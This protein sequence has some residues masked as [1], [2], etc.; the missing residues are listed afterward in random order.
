MSN[1][2]NIK[3]FC[4]TLD[5]SNLSNLSKEYQI[6]FQKSSVQALNETNTNKKIAKIV[7][8]HFNL[9]EDGSR[10]FLKTTDRKKGEEEL[11]RFSIGSTGARK[12]DILL[13]THLGTKG[14]IL[15][16]HTDIYPSKN[17]LNRMR[18]HPDLW[19]Q[20]LIKL[21]SIDFF[22]NMSIFE[23]DLW[24]DINEKTNDFFEDNDRLQLIQPGI[25]DFDKKYGSIFV[26]YLP[27]EDLDMIM[28][29]NEDSK[30][31]FWS[32]KELN[33]IIIEYTGKSSTLIV[34][35]TFW[36][37]STR[38]KIAKKYEG[39][40]ID[41][42]KG[43]LEKNVKVENSKEEIIIVNSIIKTLKKVKT[44]IWEKDKLQNIG[45]RV[46]TSRINLSLDDYKNYE[47]FKNATIGFTASA[48]KSLL[49]K[50]IRFMPEKI[51]LNNNIVNAEPILVLTFLSL[52][53]HPGSFV[54]NIQRFVSGLESATKR[55]AV[56][57]F[58]DSSI[59]EDNFKDLFSL[60]SGSLLSQRVTEWKPSKK[61]IKQWIIILLIAYQRHSIYMVDYKGEIK[62][63][64][65]T[66][67][68]DQHILKNC[69]ACLDEL[70]SFPGD[71]GLARGWAREFP[72]F[73]ISK[74]KYQPKV[75][76]IL[77][78]IDQHWAPQMVYFYNP[79]VI[80]DNGNKKC[81]SLTANHS[82]PFGPLFI[83]IF[84]QVTGINP[85]LKKGVNYYSPDFEERP[86]VKET[87]EAQ[88]LFLISLQSSQKIRKSLNTISFNYELSSSWL[89]GLIG[90]MNIKVK[91]AMTIVTLKSDDPL[92]LIVTR[93]PTSRRGQ[94]EYKPLTPEQEE[95]A[96]EIAKHRL[97]KGVYMNQAKSPDISLENC[98]AFLI[99]DDD[100][101]YYEI[102]KS[103]Q[104]NLTWDDAR[105]ITV[106]LPI[107]K[108]IKCTIKN[109]LIN[110]GE[111][112]EIDYIKKINVLL[113]NTD[114][115]I[116]RRVL[117]YLS[118]ANS[119]IE[120]HRI[121]RDGGGTAKSVDLYDIPAYQFLLKISIYA[122]GALRC[123]QGKP[124]TFIVPN[125][126]LLWEIRKI[127]ISKTMDKISEKDIKGW[128]TSRFKD[129]DR[130]I[131][132]Y[133]EETVNDIIEKHNDGLKGQFLWLRVGVG[134][135]K[136]VLT[137]LS[138]LKNTNQLPK[139]IIYTLPSESVTS[140]IEEIKMF[141]IEIN[142]MI[143]LKNIS[144]HRQ[145]YDKININVTQGC[146]PKLYC[147]NIIWHDHLRF[148][149][150][151]LPVYAS[152]SIFVFDEVHLFLNQ[153]L[154]TSMG[155]NLSHLARE[156]ISLT[157]T[158]VIDNKTEKL[159]SWLEQIVP[160]EVNKKNFWVAANNMIAK[161]IS[162]GIKTESK[163]I[164]A[165]F[166]DNEQMKYQKY[167]PP[168]M[169]GKNTN[170]SSSD[171]NKASNICYDACNRKM[172]SL[173]KQM[174]KENRGIMI[175][176]KDT[177]QQ[178]TMRDMILEQTSLK[179][180]DIFLIT[181]NNSIYLTDLAVKQKK[182][183]DYKIVIVT[184][185][186]PQGYSLTR[187]SVMI[188]SV[189]PSNNATREQLA[190]RINRIDQTTEPLLYK[191]VHI[192]ILT[193]IMKN[194]NNAKSLS[195]ALQKIAEQS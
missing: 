21:G 120:M 49:Q 40:V 85:R 132:D 76:S 39:I 62:K 178:E 75:M 162:T 61:I 73:K 41:V 53:V 181:K 100:D 129:L 84:Q 17:I 109:A 54:P 151:T 188:T 176:T 72:N 12:E 174:L 70:R 173:T 163:S 158:P 65:Y 145:Q 96:I 47:I 57:I 67:K 91:G 143:P 113:E 146:I 64:P 155:M 81:K 156:F 20:F 68:Y 135:T 103:G 112:V 42:D 15:Q 5:T 32:P 128:K 125:G 183:P 2:K 134:K 148:C 4:D 46:P 3:N 66:L 194:H 124:A 127:I 50:I 157:G 186:K 115:N 78:C 184:K 30:D 1:L 60:L 77:H 175:V 27:E 126:P 8:K 18:Q 108:K 44:N 123:I 195:V 83:N 164:L 137:Y 101:S 52:L 111:G 14:S 159:I 192:G 177:S 121:S 51:E 59:P 95:E 58:E 33:D 89:A 11:S 168:A 104:P 9:N 48:Y 45:F 110:I 190:G 169:G 166:T 26:S 171:W 118:T 86:F 79:T 24:L 140:I 180:K 93:Q 150:E 106:T 119:I 6:L 23:R 165:S 144:K 98:K 94:T 191:T 160:F 153:S 182:V 105:D 43:I 28:S 97:R 107:H 161:K 56:T 154:R 167:V 138:Y 139:Y 22:S 114:K 147:I 88:N 172:V 131:F 63:E 122:P 10:I 38:Y 55:L 13:G 37:I 31:G 141:G 25:G 116:L 189:Y 187:L 35:K 82:K 102:R 74:S 80:L 7:L 71:L 130:K 179:N 16:V 87:R 19:S 152:D 193:T 136:I 36:K 185:Q 29:S 133:Q 149:N 69:S 142:V 170:P 90:V 117:I 34:L 99:E 92:D